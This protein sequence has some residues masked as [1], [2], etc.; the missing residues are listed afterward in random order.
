MSD[1]VSPGK[2]IQQL[3]QLHKHLDLKEIHPLELIHIATC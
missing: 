3:S 2:I 1:N